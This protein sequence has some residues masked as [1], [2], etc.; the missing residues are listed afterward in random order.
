[1]I[2]MLYMVIACVNALGT[3]QP[4]QL[5]LT[6]W[7]R[8]QIEMLKS[9]ECWILKKKMTRMLKCQYWIQ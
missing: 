7:C 2:S 5:I 4:K 3:D 9:Q 8:C 1:V 6:D